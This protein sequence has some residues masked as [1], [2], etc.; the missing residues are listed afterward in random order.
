MSLEW[1]KAASSSGERSKEKEAVPSGGTG[2]NRGPGS[3][4]L[5]L[6]WQQKRKRIVGKL[7]SRMK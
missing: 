6:G 7:Q 2:D 3:V 5:H 1:R 4:K